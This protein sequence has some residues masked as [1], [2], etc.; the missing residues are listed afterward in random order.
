MKLAAVDRAK[1]GRFSGGTR[2][3]GYAHTDTRT[4]RTMDDFGKVTEEL[5]PSG[6]LVLVLEEADAIAW[7]Y[8]RIASGGSLRE[9]TREWRSRGWLGRPGRA[10]PRLR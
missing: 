2:R 5:R 8:R 1:K 6:P 3:F 4:A 7:G 9:V 10:S